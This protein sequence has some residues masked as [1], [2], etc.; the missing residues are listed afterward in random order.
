MGRWDFGGHSLGVGWGGLGGEAQMA[1]A[2]F[3]RVIYSYPTQELAD[4]TPTGSKDITEVSAE[5]KA[6][7]QRWHFL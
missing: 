3:M 2:D 6:K 7:L 1:A 5:E 4:Y